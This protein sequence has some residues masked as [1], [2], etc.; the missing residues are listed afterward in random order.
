MLVDPGELDQRISI[1]TEQTTADGMGGTTTSWSTVATV[2][3]K[4]RPLTGKEREQG[5]Q[6]ESP[7]TYAVIM[8]N[9]TVSEAQRLKWDSNGDL[10]LN[11]RFV[12]RQARAQ[13]IKIEAEMGV[14]N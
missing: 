8:R 13:Y 1:Q 4:V 2:W 10:I 11:I 6:V 9:R 7:A 5:L 14:V 12:G 3:A